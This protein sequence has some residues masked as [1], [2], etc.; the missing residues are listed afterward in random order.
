MGECC[1]SDRGTAYQQLTDASDRTQCLLPLLN[2]PLIAWTLE[3]LSASNVKVV[4][5]LIREGA[6]ELQEWLEWV[7]VLVGVDNV[8]LIPL[9]A[10]RTVQ[11]IYVR[12][13]DS[14]YDNSHKTDTSTQ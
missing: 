4:H 9:A 3:S 11:I 12:V 13:P 6:R 5:I 7:H 2:A 14:L 10:P 1:R 8:L